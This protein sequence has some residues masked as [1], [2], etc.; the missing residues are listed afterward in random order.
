[1]KASN[2]DSVQATVPPTQHKMKVVLTGSTGFIGGGV[3]KQCI[4]N[5]DID[6]LIILSRRQLPQLQ[7][8]P[9]VKVVIMQDF[10][11]YPSEVLKDIDGS[12]GCI[13]YFLSILEVI[14]CADTIQV[15]RYL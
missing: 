4:A 11:H 5:T 12:D 7:G 8:N 9:K 2:L 6:L 15:I 10:L 1:M 3:L 14:R 13:W